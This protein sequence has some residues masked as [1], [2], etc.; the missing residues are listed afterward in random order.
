MRTMKAVLLVT[1]LVVGAT[2]AHAGEMTFGLGGGMSGPTGDFGKA[3]K[4]GFNG[5]V[6]G[7]YWLKP[8]Y[9]LGIDI[10]GNFVSAKDEQKNLLNQTAGTTG[11]DETFDT[12]DFN[13]H[14][15]W[16]PSMQNS[17]VQPWLTAGLGLYHNQSK[18]TGAGIYDE[19]ASNNKFGF[20]GGVGADMKAGSAMKVGV[21]F[22]YHYV[23]SAIKV[24]NGAG[25]TDE[26]AANF[27]TVGVHLTFA[28]SGAK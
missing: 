12:F 5:N 18:I 25:G 10:D 16:Q 9:A 19:T 8:V 2:A 27:Y 14:G 11:A 20:H 7:D 6:Y 23:P 3:F 24:S 4:T 13:V 17:P 26:K 22:K 28:T 21:D 1:A 15:V